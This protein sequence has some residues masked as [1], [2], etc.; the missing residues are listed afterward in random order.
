MKKLILLLTMSSMIA[1]AQF[2]EEEWTQVGTF[3]DPVAWHKESGPQIGLEITKVML[4]GWASV[5]VSH[6]EALTPVYSDLVGSG[7]INF[8]LFNYNPVRYY[9]GPRLGFMWREGNG[10]PLVGGVMGFD[11]R[12]SSKNAETKFHIGLRGWIDYREDQKNQ[13]YGD[14]DGYEP[15]IITNNPLLQENGAIVISI[16]FN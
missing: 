4:W 11:W 10:F 5:Q 6:F 3:V 1:Q 13:F 14:S 16:S 7:G 15:G 8:N 9:A 2:I 12:L